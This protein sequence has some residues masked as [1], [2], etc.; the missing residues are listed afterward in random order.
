MLFRSS[1][2]LSESQKVQV[3]NALDRATNVKEV[4]LVY[5]SLK[6]AT[7]K[8]NRE[9]VRE[10]VGFASKP[11]GVAPK[12]NIVEADQFINRWQK[13]AGIKK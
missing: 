2:S 3:I 5:E 4:K 9:I 8:K 7:Q 6:E 12:A 13:L 1:K 11:A 10:S